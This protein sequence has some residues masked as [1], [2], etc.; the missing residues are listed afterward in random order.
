MVEESERLKVL[1]LYKTRIDSQ[2]K[3]KVFRDLVA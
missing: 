3:T 2:Q 1:Q